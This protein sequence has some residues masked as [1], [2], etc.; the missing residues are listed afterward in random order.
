[1]SSNTPRRVRASII[2]GATAVLAAALTPAAADPLTLQG[3]TTFNARLMAPYQ[4]AIEKE[5][6]QQLIVVP[7]KSNLGILA[8]FEKRAGLAMISAS[9][10]AEIT[11]LKRTKP[12]LPFDRLQAFEVARTRVAFGVHP[13]NPIRSADR[14]TMRRILLGEIKNWR[15]IGG[16]DLPIR[17]VTPREGGGVPVSIENELLGGRPISAP[18]IIK[19]QIGSQVPKVVGQEP[20]A[21]GLAQL[22]LLRQHN[23]PEITIDPPVAQVLVLVT[24]GE[25][26]QAMKDVIKAAR[27][28]ASAK[29]D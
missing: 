22:G 4:S 23:L 9:L 28:V 24:L 11:A 10:E 25:P 26:T 21:L 14:A 19:V 8:L 13:S 6:G 2:G 29:L 17:I 18:D 12:N 7:N 1:M 3:S 20:S 27:D 5:S 16:A 15:E